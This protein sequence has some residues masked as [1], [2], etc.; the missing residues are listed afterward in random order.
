MQNDRNHRK[1]ST[2]FSIPLSFIYVQLIATK[3]PAERGKKTAFVQY[4]AHK[5]FHLG[6]FGCGDHHIAGFYEPHSSEE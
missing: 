1:A 4:G 3:Q 6:L 5:V 2:G